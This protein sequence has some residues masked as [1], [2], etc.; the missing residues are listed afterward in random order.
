[1]KPLDRFWRCLIVAVAT[2]LSL[3]AQGKAPSQMDLLDDR[4]M[5]RVGD[6]LIYQVL[7]E[8]EPPQV[9]FV[10]DRGRVDLPLIDEMDAAGKTPRQL[11]YLIKEELEQTFF[12]R[13][14]VLVQFQHGQNSRG[15]I[16]LVG[17]VARPGPV[18]IPADEILT[19]SAA[20]TRAGSILPGADLSRV[21]LVR[22]NAENAE[23]EERIIVDVR[24][25][26]EFGNL[27]ADVIV[28]PNDIIIV[29]ESLSAGGR[30]YVTGM[31]NREGV[32]SLPAN[33]EKLTVSEAILNAGG[34]RQYASKDAVQVVRSDPELPDS[35]RKLR[36]NVEAILR[37]REVETDV[38][39]RPGD[40]IHVR[41]VFFSW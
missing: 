27:A 20:I 6:Y 25:V 37:G 16:N 17:R 41:E 9:V 7:E 10:N 11:A 4:R 22:D 18:N 32:Y 33:G 5:M 23:E 8:R 40:I 29:P 13:A 3:T 26:L 39:V 19:V 38:A 34:F 15:R 21:E 36:V 12:H 35:E 28:R 24:D 30:F 1:M 14:T 2:C 31:V